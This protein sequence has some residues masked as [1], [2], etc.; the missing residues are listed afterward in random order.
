[1]N[2]LLISACGYLTSVYAL[3]AHDGRKMDLG[4]HIKHHHYR[5]CNFGLYCGL[6]DSIFGT[7]YNKKKYPTEYVPTYLIK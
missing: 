3:M 7:R 5:T 2:P 1:M 4:D 6:W